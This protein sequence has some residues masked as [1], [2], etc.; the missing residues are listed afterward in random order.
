MYIGRKKILCA[1]FFIKKIKS[2]NGQAGMPILS[3]KFSYYYLL[4]L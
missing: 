4:Q 1:L 3:F 2:F